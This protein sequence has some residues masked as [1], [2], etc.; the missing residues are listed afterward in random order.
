MA[1][2]PKPVVIKFFCNV[3]EF[4]VPQLLEIIDK[5]LQAGVSEFT[6]LISSQ[7]GSVF[8]GISA[9]NY[10]KGIPAKVRT[11]NFG[12]VNSSAS[13][14]FC[15]GDE[16]FSVPDGTFLIHPVRA[17][18]RGGENLAIDDLEERIKGVKLDSEN[19]AG[20][21]SSA[22]GKTEDEILEMMRKRT[23]LNPEE[24]K[25]FGFVHEIKEALFDSGSEIIN[26]D[27]KPPKT[28]VLPFQIQRQN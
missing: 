9:Y 20:V 10:L 25:E 16:R 7:G 17:A 4:S 19:I 11:H 6:I 2:N 23:N 14:I 8:H 1:S 5:K 18:F 15:A 26:I 28:Q 12:S 24:A 22:T 3:N 21:I 27:D 13:V